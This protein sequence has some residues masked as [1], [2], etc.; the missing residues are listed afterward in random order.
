MDD[1]WGI[2]SHLT[3]RLSTTSGKDK[4]FRKCSKKFQK[5]L[6]VS[7]LFGYFA[8][9]NYKIEVMTLTIKDFRNQMAHSFDRADAGERGGGHDKFSL[10]VGIGIETV[11]RNI[12]VSSAAIVH[13]R[14]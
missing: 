2:V 7:H 8:N 11:N 10:Q 9:E 5:R 12:S 13:R 14:A 6:V 3:N 1:E 4:N